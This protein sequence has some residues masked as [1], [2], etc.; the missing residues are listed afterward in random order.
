MP[1]EK[2]PKKP[3]ENTDKQKKKEPET[4]T[5]ANEAAA[6]KLQEASKKTEPEKKKEKQWKVGLGKTEVKTQ[7]NSMEV[8]TAGL[9]FENKKKNM[10][11]TVGVATITETGKPGSFPEQKR[12]P[13]ISFAKKF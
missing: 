10:E 2:T 6:K 5:K 9:K 11:F 1:E 7:D 8:S 4:R 13:G 3:A 12:M